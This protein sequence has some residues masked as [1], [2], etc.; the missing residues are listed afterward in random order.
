MDDEGFY[1]LLEALSLFLPTAAENR[2]RVKR[3]LEEKRGKQPKRMFYASR[4]EF[5]KKRPRT[6]DGKFVPRCH[7]THVSV[8][9]HT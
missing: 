5:A 1:E 3:R 2:A 4:S 8:D 7:S 6:A 9:D